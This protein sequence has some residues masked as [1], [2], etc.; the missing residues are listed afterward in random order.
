M[1]G[2]VDRFMATSGSCLLGVVEELDFFTGHSHALTE[3]EVECNTVDVFDLG[4]L[5][6][7]RDQLILVENRAVLA[8]VAK[9]RQ[10]RTIFERGD[11][12]IGV[13]VDHHKVTRFQER[14]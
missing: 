13:V 3:F 2:S 10:L 11:D 9:T 5:A 7:V 4:C 6:V 14:A 1:F 8:G 12:V